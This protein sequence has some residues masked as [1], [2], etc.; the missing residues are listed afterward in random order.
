MT[1]TADHVVGGF[2]QLTSFETQI[3]STEGIRKISWTE[4][5]TDQETV[6]PESNNRLVVDNLSVKRGD[7][8][9]FKNLSLSLDE[10]DKMLITGPSGVGKSTL[11]NAIAG[12][13]PIEKGE[14]EFGGHKLK[15][16]DFVFISQNIWLFAGT[17]RENLSLLQNF[18]DQELVAALNKVG[19]DKELGSK[20]LDFEIKE[21]GSNLSGGQAQR[22]AIARGLYVIRR[23]FY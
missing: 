10:N 7:R 9:I 3:Q 5:K 17:V 20:A 8:E 16:S 2:R 4:T 13:I 23:Y 6:L 21:Q 12:Y 22:L 11:L 1:L 14:V 19:L 18:T 15:Y